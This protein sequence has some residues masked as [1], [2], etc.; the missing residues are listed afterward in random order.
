MSVNLIIDGQAY[1][2]SGAATE[3]TLTRLANAL[4]RSNDGKQGIGKTIKDFGKGVVDQ[5]KENK[6]TT[7]SLKGLGKGADDVADELDAA[8]TSARSFASRARG[9]INGLLDGAKGLVQF[10]GTTAGTGM[11]MSSLAQSV[12][13]F[14]SKFGAL[15]GV[16]GATG[17]AIVAHSANLIDTFDALSNTGAAFTNNLFDLERVAANSYLSLEQMTGM[18]R[19]NS[20][21]LA[22][23]G[24][25]AR[26]GAKRFA[27]MNQVVQDTYRRDFAMLGLKASDSAEM[28]ASFTA[29]QARNTQFSTMGVNEQARAGANFVKEIT[30]LANLTGQDRKQLAEKLAT[31]KRRADVELGLSRMQGEAA[32]RARAAFGVMEQSFGAGSPMMDALRTS[33]LKL[34][35]ASSTAAN[36]LLQDNTMGPVLARI[37]EGLRNGSMSMTDIQKEF[38]NVSTNFIGANKGL[39]GVAQYSDIAMAFTEVSAGLLNFQKQRLVVEKQYNG[40]YEAFVK[41]QKP[42]LDATSVAL[43]D[44]QLAIQDFGKQVRLGFNAFTESSV[45]LM[46]KGVDSLN[47]IMSKLPTSMAQLKEMIGDNAGAGLTGTM[48]GL[49]VATAK[50]IEAFNKLRGLL[51]GASKVTTGAEQGLSKVAEQT[52]KGSTGI[53]SKISGFLGKIG[54]G[55]GILGAGAQAVN[56]YQN[57]E[58]KTTTGKVIEGAGSGVGTFAGGL[59]GAKVGGAL[60]AMLGSFVPI[61]G[62]VI[63]GAIGAIG[64]GIGGALL[65][66][67]AF[68]AAARDIGKFLGFAEGGIVTQPIM[69]AAIAEKPGT[70]EGVFPLPNDFKADDLGNLKD[71]Q[72][73]GKGIDNLASAMAGFS[74]AELVEQMKL[75]NRNIKVVAQRLT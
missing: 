42:N 50:V 24:G 39:E 58:M 13:G 71:I 3:A 6:K 41:A 9:M 18:L 68:S 64:G 32:G 44:T 62:N 17:G 40:D 20:E 14:G 65:G 37:T 33:F 1:E 23:F 7:M 5:A 52:A 46:K 66:D 53:F 61:I 36:M 48:A 45:G 31:D 56:T 34:P 22:V 60:G 43:K 67:E 29:M 12:E 30:M 26:L 57:S 25:S 8:A 35:A 38:A 11:N 54:T 4:E 69:G 47:E 27:E 51:P 15:G 21:S 19:A 63:G 28:L 73:I 59:A 55:L 16:L 10:A 49:K 75:F 74:N 72:K 2:L 70:A